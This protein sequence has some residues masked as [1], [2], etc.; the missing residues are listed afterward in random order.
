M[1]DMPEPPKGSPPP[2]A[3][4]KMPDPPSPPNVD[5]AIQ[6][7]AQAAINFTKDP[8]LSEVPLI[9]KAFAAEKAFFEKANL[10]KYDNPAIRYL[11]VATYLSGKTAVKRGGRKTYRRHSK[12]RK[13]RKH[14]SA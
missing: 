5:D 10:A 1:F 11:T 7:L 4:H 2:P 3:M 13:T 9:N 14:V 6:I 8:I 12:S